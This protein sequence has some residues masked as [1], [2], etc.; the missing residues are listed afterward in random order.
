MPYFLE[1]FICDQNVADIL[2][3]RYTKAH[4]VNLDQGIYLVPFTEELC[5]QLSNDTVSPTIG[6]FENLTEHIENEILKLL[7]EQ[8]IAFVEVQ[9]HG[10]DGGQIAIIWSSKK[11]IFLLEFGEDR[12]NEVLKYFGVHVNDDQ[13]EFATLRLGA[14]KSTEG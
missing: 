11:R 13:D 6:D 5:Q 1:A 4:K 12:V 9:Y 10:G 2:T 14:H 8:K 3:S 7:P